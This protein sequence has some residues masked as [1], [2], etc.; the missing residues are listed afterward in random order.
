M[1]ALFIDPTGTSRS[2]NFMYQDGHRKSFY[3]GKDHMHLR[4]DM[5]VCQAVL[6]RARLAHFHIP[7]WAR[8]LLPVAKGLG[9]TV[10]CDLQDV[11]SADDDYRRD[12]V[13]Y[14][15]ILFL[16]A[17]NYEDPTPLIER[18]LEV[19]S[20]EVVIV[21]MGARGCAL[22]TRHRVRFFAPVGMEAP[23]IDTN[24][25]GDSL[26]VGFLSSYVLDGYSLSDSI[27]RGQIVA[28]YA[29]AQRGSSSNLIT[30]E[31]LD[32][33]FAESR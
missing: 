18:L 13:Q 31:L 33:Y 19:N 12:F 1:T 2:I 10:S 20:S 16:S 27:R 6:A 14:A 5:A 32:R 3:D 7:N 25:A 22:G 29:C 26:A 11:V 28:R 21:G 23:V 4:P 9:V 30:P 17:V 15:D 24:G 8:Y